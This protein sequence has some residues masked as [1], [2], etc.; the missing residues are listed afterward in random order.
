MLAGLALRCAAGSRRMLS[1]QASSSIALATARA[2]KKAPREEAAQWTAEE[3]AYTTDALGASAKPGEE[4][5]ADAAAAA[6]ASAAGDVAGTPGGPTAAEVAASLQAAAAAT[7]ARLERRAGRPAP[8]AFRQPRTQAAAQR[9][10]FALHPAVERITVYTHSVSRGSLWEFVQWQVPS[11]RMTNPSV[12]IVISPNKTAF[13]AIVISLNSQKAKRATKHTNVY[14]LAAQPA[15]AAQ[16]PEFTKLAKSFHAD[17]AKLYPIPGTEERKQATNADAATDA[18]AETGGFEPLT[19]EP[20]TPASNAADDMLASLFG[21]ASTSATDAT[22]SDS[23]APASEGLDAAEQQALNDR[24]SALIES[25]KTHLASMRDQ[26]HRDV[27]VLPF[28]EADKWSYEDICSVVRIASREAGQPAAFSE[29]FV[30]DSAVA[31]AP[32][33]E[34]LKAALARK[35]SASTIY[36]KRVLKLRAAQKL[37]DVGKRKGAGKITA[38]AL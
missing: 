3:L 19:Q 1:S 10:G 16:W 36:H 21:D 23:S 27:I 30:A 33:P 2:G 12:P 13:P 17:F 8:I 6:A 9:N 11:L 22:S 37:A 35:A 5:G 32:V 15:F 7:A 20:T 26:Q 34:R 29:M 25:Y 31:M 4:S 24:L 28:L 38:A 14:G 18:A